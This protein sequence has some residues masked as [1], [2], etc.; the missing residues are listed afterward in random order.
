M[1]TFLM[2]YVSDSDDTDEG[3]RQYRR[4]YQAF[5]VLSSVCSCWY[6]TLVGWLHKKRIEREYFVLSVSTHGFDI[7]LRSNH[8]MKSDDA[9]N[10]MTVLMS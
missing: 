4:K 7:Y 2:I 9:N 1:R 10:W 3:R 8:F 6:F 5:T